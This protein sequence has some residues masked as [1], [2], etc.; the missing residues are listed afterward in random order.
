[1]DLMRELGAPLE[2]D[3][4]QHGFYYTQPNYAFPSI[5]LTESEIIA[6][7]VNDQLLKQYRNAPYYEEI[8][9]V[10]AK[11]MQFLPAETFNEENAAIFSFVSPPA[12][13]VKRRQF[14]ILQHAAAAEKQVQIKYYSPHSNTESERSVDPYTI[15][16]QHG[17]WY[18]IGFCHLRNEFRIFA[19]NRILTIECT[20]I[21]F[22]KPG[23]FSVERFLENSFGIYLDPKIYHVK[24]KFP[25]YEARWIRERQWHKSQKMTTT[26][27]G[28][29][30][31]EMD[32][33][34]LE[35]VKRWVLQ[36]GAE[37]E[38]LEPAELREAIGREVAGLQKK[39]F[40]GKIG[41]I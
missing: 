3:Q 38:V 10:I 14:E 28:S 16:N 7:T 12:S 41:G 6:M 5:S 22:Y 31:L 17:T 19:L 2:Y 32:V 24:L 36:Y 15:R 39:Y 27:D 11:I 25:A 20:D 35:D 30:I 29:L 9:K 8:K 33:K 1:M 18:L 21:D 23:S 13:V 37:V 40:N 34:G 26:E 4:H